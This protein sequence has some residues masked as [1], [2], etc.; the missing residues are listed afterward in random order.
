MDML[1]GRVTDVLSQIMAGEVLESWN[2]VD[3]TCGKIQTLYQ[4]KEDDI[5]ILLCKTS[6]NISSINLVVMCETLLMHFSCANRF[7]LRF[8]VSR[9]FHL[10]RLKASAIPFWDWGVST[11]SLGCHAL[12][13][14]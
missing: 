7:L 4:E 10:C 12:A 8:G 3:L 6:T 1:W 9:D 2:H 14:I 13:G 11:V 5:R